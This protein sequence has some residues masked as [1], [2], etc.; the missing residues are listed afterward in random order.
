MHNGALYVIK[1]QQNQY[2]LSEEGQ[3]GDDLRSSLEL[4]PTPLDRVGLSQGALYVIFFLVMNT[5]F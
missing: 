2:N 5:F 1:D 4:P 3:E